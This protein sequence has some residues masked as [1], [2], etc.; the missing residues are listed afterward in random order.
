MN[1]LILTTQNNSSCLYVNGLPLCPN[2]Y[3]NT[4][5]TGETGPTGAISTVTGPTG[6]TGLQGTTGPTG[7]T[8]PQGTTGPTGPTGLQ[9]TTGPTG[10]EQPNFY[11]NYTIVTITSTIGDNIFFIPGSTTNSSYSNVYQVDTTNAPLTIYLPLI[12][13]LDNNQRRI[14]YIVDSAGQLS[15]NNLIITPAPSDTI[16]G[17]TSLTLTVNYSSV[18]IISNTTDKWLIV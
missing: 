11:T 15:N 17:Q 7:E 14:H 3:G 4:G 12:S 1:G 2:N 6:P 10:P 9:G 5:P 13:N 8:G 18:Q 16:A